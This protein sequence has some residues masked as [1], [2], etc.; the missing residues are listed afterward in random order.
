MIQVIATITD[1][2]RNLIWQCFLDT[3]RLVRYYE[4]LS[5]QYRRKHFW[6]RVVLLAV[7]TSGVVA[8]F[9]LFPKIVQIVAGGLVALCVVWDFASDYAKKA[10]TLHSISIECSALEVE[11]QDLWGD[12]GRIDDAEARQRNTRLSRRLTEVTGW[13][14]HTNIQ[15]DRKLNERCEAAAYR[16]M[17]DQYGV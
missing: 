1:Q 15:E 10:A 5:D 9:D 13:A 17:E 16:V 12:L 7:A 6:I 2:T 11:W 14:G 8:L 4:A 3:A